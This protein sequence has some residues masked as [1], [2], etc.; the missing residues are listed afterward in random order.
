MTPFGLL[1]RLFQDRFFENDS[2]S[3]GGGFET[4][5]Y[6][7]LGF[8]AATGFMV[9][10]LIMPVFLELSVARLPAGRAAAEAGWALRSFRLFFPAVSFA[11]IGFT[12]VFEWDTLFPDRRD[13]LILASFP[14]RLREVFAAKVAALGIFLFLLTGALNIF[15]TLMVTAFVAGNPHLRMTGLQL[16]AAQ[17]LATV[18]ASVFAF[19]AVASFQG[20]LINLTSARLF[21]RVSPWIQMAGMSLTIL[22]LLTYP[23]Y[24]M[25]LRAAAENHRLWLWFFP[26]VWFT[27]FYDILLPGG[28]PLFASLGNFAWRMLGIVFLLFCLTWALGFRRHYRRTLEAEDTV[29]RVGRFADSVRI[30]NR[31]RSTTAGAPG[32]IFRFTGK[33]LARSTK[34]QLFLATYMSVGIAIALLFTLKVRAGRLELSEDGLLSA[35]F[36]IVF[37]AISGFRAVFQFPAELASNWLFRITESRWAETARSAIRRQVLRMGLLPA[38]LLLLPIEMAAHGWRIGLQHLVFQLAAGALLIELMFWSFDKVPF[39]C[40]YFAGKI[41]LSVLAVFYLYGLTIYSFQMADL[42][43]W[44]EGH[45]WR[46]VLVYTAAGVALTVFRRRHPAAAEVRF[47]A[48]EPVIQTLDLS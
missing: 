15:P 23:I 34:H 45:A 10:Y 5:I 17:V 29:P 31:P 27:G 43:R 36:L 7:V 8:L 14:I 38:L 41:S 40:S 13:F 47:D 32:A 48:S 21:R 2:V 35:P 24:S 33:T 46:T 37:F 11:V 1:L 16:V 28:D 12:T 42:E 26:P 22:S 20:L 44:M 6:Q 18:G 25:L 19:L 30:R 3:P 9:S 4:N 39:T